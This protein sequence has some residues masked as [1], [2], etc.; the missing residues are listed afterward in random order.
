MNN[1]TEYLRL[2]VIAGYN[3]IDSDI[4]TSS[5]PYVEIHVPYL[6]P[7]KTKIKRNN[8]NPRWNEE[9]IIKVSPQEHKLILNVF[10]RDHATSDDFLGMVKL[11]LTNIL[12]ERFSDGS[13]NSNCFC[14][15]FENLVQLRNPEMDPVNKFRFA[16]NFTPFLVF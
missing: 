12:R 4:V 2:K 15:G 11:P 3:L 10:D 13:V 8:L 5:D 14:F 7:R 6:K 1:A 16:F 9:F